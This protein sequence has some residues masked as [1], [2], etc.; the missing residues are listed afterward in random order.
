MIKY[1]IDLAS[2][3]FAFVDLDNSF[4][5]FNSINNILYLVYTSKNNS[6]I[7]YDLNN[8]KKINEIKSFQKDIISSYRHISDIKNKRDLIMSI[9]RDI[10]DIKIAQCCHHFIL[11][12]ILCY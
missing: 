10:N 4:C 5:V 12:T 11:M 9:S 7:F 2:D 1:F 3:S 8:F 6:I